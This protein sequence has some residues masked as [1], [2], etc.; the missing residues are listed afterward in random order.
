[1][2]NFRLNFIVCS[3]MHTTIENLTSDHV[4]GRTFKA[5]LSTIYPLDSEHCIIRGLHGQ[6]AD[7]SLAVMLC[8]VDS[9]TFLLR[10]SMRSLNALEQHMKSTNCTH[11]F[12]Q[13]CEDF[14]KAKILF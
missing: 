4:G 12:M 9:I 14:T 13:N 11:I 3:Y 8:E 5:I 1:M 2:F 7:F 6:C 10:C